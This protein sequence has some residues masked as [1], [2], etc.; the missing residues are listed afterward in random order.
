MNTNDL[1]PDNIK[2]G[3]LYT[4]V[5]SPET[6]SLFALDG[7][8]CSL[9]PGEKRNENWINTAKQ[10]GV[11]DDER[12]E[13]ARYFIIHKNRFIEQ[14]SV[15]TEIPNS[16]S[17]Y[18]DEWCLNR[19]NH[20]VNKTD[21]YILF[22]H[23]HPSGLA[24]PSDRDKE[25]TKFISNYFKNAGNN[26]TR[27]LGHIIIG[28]NNN[29]SFTDSKAENWMGIVNNSCV[30]LQ[31]IEKHPRHNYSF[32]IF[33]DNSYAKMNAYTNFLLDKNSFD[34]AKHTVFLYSNVAGYITG[35]NVMENTSILNMKYS[36]FHNMVRK[37]SSMCG[38]SEC[39]AVLPQ[40]NKN[41]LDSIKYKNSVSNYIISNI[42]INEPDKLSCVY[43]ENKGFV[44]KENE[45]VEIKKND[46]MKTPYFLR[47]KNQMNTNENINK[48]FNDYELH[49]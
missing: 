19:L 29:F 44:Y 26:K 2:P 5:K 3:S 14:I 36:D 46:S 17:V 21:S 15:T 20:F 33:G 9:I 4:W 37:Y 18:K 16:T 1:I 40:N 22:A 6:T 42:V 27:F 25:V 8:I 49:G 34:P 10:I 12:Y 41:L 32:D 48:S 38:G 45:K 13:T 47:T 30:P 39:F 7:K 28:G 35:I 23:N 43:K 31:F 11:Y 24:S